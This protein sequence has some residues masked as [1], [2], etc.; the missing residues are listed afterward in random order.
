[1]RSVLKSTLGSYFAK[2]EHEKLKEKKA[3]KQEELGVVAHAEAGGLLR[4]GGV[5]G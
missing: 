1:M 5:H 2:G 3:E 4:V